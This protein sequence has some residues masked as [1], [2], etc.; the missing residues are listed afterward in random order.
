MLGSVANFVL[1]V[2][3]HLI[4]TPNLKVGTIIMFIS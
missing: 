4:L 1:H 3:L 2:L